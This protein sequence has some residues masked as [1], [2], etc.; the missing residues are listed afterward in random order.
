MFRV[1][2]LFLKQSSNPKTILEVSDLNVSKEEGIEGSKKCLNF[3]QVLILPSSTFQE[4]KINAGELNENI[5]SEGFDVHTLTSGTVLEINEVKI[6]L[7]YHCEPCGFVNKW[8]SIKNIKFKRGYLGSFL[9]SGNIIV[10]NEIK[11]LET[12]F[13]PIPYKIEDRII[14]FLEKQNKTVTTQQLLEGVGLSNGFRRAIPA[15]LKRID[16]KYKKMVEFKKG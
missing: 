13:E 16:E 10:G 5:V 3:R 6:R 2:K 4:F 8:T 15:Y 7:T 11:I 1:Q 9:N 14:W 12:K